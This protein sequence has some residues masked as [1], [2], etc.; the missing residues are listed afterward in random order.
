MNRDELIKAIV[1]HDDHNIK[2][3]FYEYRFLSN[4]EPC[5]VFFQGEYYS[6]SENAYQAAKTLDGVRKSMIQN[7]S[8]Y[9]SKREGNK[10]KKEGTIR[11]DWDEV[12]AEV[13]Y[14]IVLD[15]FTRNAS[16]KFQL[17]ATGDKYLEEA[18]YWNDTF[19]GVC[20]GVGLNMLGKILMKT[21]EK[22]QK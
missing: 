2:G 11:P 15:K 18:N 16:L 9:E 8:P 21:R 17:I 7:M 20:K 4:M 6:S 19:F 12:K 14:S 10:I 1:Q 5:T 22:I 13:M 3:F